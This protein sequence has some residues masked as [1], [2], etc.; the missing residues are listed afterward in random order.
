MPAFEDAAARH[1]RHA[2]R[3]IMLAI[4]T[5]ATRAGFLA[6]SATKRGSTVPGFSL[7]HRTSEVAPTIRSCR[8]YLSPIFVMRPKRSLPPLELCRGVIH[9]T[10]DRRVRDQGCGQSLESRLW[11]ERS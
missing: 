11:D 8:R 10:E 1:D 5:E 2:I 6:S 9:F 3:A 4:A 7:A